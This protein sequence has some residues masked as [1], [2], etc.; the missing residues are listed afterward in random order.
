MSAVGGNSENIYSLKVLPPITPK[1]TLLPTELRRVE[2]CQLSAVPASSAGAVNAPP[3]LPHHRVHIGEVPNL[4]ELAVFD[5]I[6]SEL[7]NSHPT[8]RRLNS[9]EGPPA[10]TGDL[11][12]HRD[13]V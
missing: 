12:L 3:D 1:Q 10:G 2:R 4:G 9:L 5:A 11:E 6:K 8:S 7:R 13:I